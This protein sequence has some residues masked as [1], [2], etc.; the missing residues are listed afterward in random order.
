MDPCCLERPAQDPYSKGK[1]FSDT[2]KAPQ[3]FRTR[4]F[5]ATKI[6]R[7]TETSMG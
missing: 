5:K 2:L 1:A 7:T 4:I 6:A 3:S